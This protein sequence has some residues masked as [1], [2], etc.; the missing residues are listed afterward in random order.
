MAAAAN[1]VISLAGML[2]QRYHLSTE[3]IYSL[4]VTLS[5]SLLQLSHTPWLIHSWT[6]SNILFLR[7]KKASVSRIDFK[8]P[9]LT[10]EHIHGAAIASPRQNDSRNVLALAILLVEIL[11]R[12]PIE[13]LRRPQ[14][15]GTDQ[16]P[17]EFTDLQVMHIW[18]RE[19]EELGNLTSVFRSAISHC[20][21]CFVGS[22]LDLT[23]TES[24][25]SIE[26][27][28]LSPLQE[29]MSFLFR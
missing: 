15:M 11:S 4:S 27:Q 28:V 1:D 9:Y 22:A 3:E 10:T 7:A 8:H 21:K 18:I 5:S 24:R 16:Q 6:K 13:S 17:N 2:D 20:L 14:D 29:E 19:Q 23:D 25:V 12:Q 26:E